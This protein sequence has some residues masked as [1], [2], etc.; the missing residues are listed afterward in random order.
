M[1]NEYNPALSGKEMSA[2][3]DN[4]PSYLWFRCRLEFDIVDYR[5]R[6][7]K[8]KKWYQRK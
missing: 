1:A 8:N 6:K 4:L 7:Y 3:L 2:W 5:M